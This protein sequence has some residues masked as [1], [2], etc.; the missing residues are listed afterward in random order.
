MIFQPLKP[1]ISGKAQ[2]NGIEIYYEG[3]G[4]PANPS[5]LLAMGLDA[6]CVMWTEYFMQ[7]LIDAG[8]FLIRYDNRDLGLSTWME[9]W[10]RK[11]PYTLED[12]ASDAIGVL[13]ALNIQKTHLIGVSMGGMISQRISISYPERVLTLTSIM[14]SGYAL[15]PA[16]QTNVFQKI[17]FKAAPF[18]IRN[19]TIKNR[20][21]NHEVSVENYVK[22]YH[23]LAGTKFPLNEDYFRALF[24]YSILERKG[25]NPKSRLQ[26]WYAVVMSGSRLKELGQ[27]K[28]PTLILHG[29]AD[30]L[31]PHRH[32]EKYAKLIPNSK[33]VLME[34]IGHEMPK[35]ELPNIHGHI[36]THLGV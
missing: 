2:T 14:S 18:I 32:S 11:N 35:D 30:R 27:I 6:Q 4:N 3:F 33:L 7:P 36:L 31:V 10:N 26:H 16:L 12:M 9:G 20:F 13:D 8:F 24:T 17:I 5:I 15:D 34:G 19:F 23:F 25:Q 21:T 22:T 29:T 1:D 28:I